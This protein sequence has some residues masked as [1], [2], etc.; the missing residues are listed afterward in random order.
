MRL[1]TVA[2]SGVTN[3]RTGRQMAAAAAHVGEPTI[4]ILEGGSGRSGAELRLGA[5]PAVESLRRHRVPRRL[6]LAFGL[7]CAGLF[8]GVQA[9][10][11]EPVVSAEVCLDTELAQSAA[12][13]DGVLVLA[14]ALLDL[15]AGGGESLGSFP[16]YGHG[17]LSG[18]AQAL[19]LLA[20]LVKGCIVLL[21][22]R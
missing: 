22:S 14:E 20:S 18:V 6:E 4:S 21:W 5:D 7:V 9:T 16:E 17:R 13:D 11:R 8:E 19:R 2:S 12:G 1:F 15:L 10:E 3:D